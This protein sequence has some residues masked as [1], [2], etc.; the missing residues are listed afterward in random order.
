MGN[1][2]LVSWVTESPSNQAMSYGNIAMLCSGDA[3]EGLSNPQLITKSNYTALVPSTRHEYKALASYFKNFTGSPTN[4]TYLYWMGSSAAVSGTALGT[5]LIW[6]IKY[7]PYTS[8]DT[9]WVDPTG[10]SNWQAV[11]GFNITTC[12]SGYIAITGS[13]SQYN[14]YINF[15]GVYINDV[16]QGGPYFDSGGV[17]Y[18]GQIGRD[19]IDTSGGR[20]QIRATRSPF[21]VAAQN[22]IPEDIQ[23]LVAPYDVAASEPSGIMG[24]ASAV[25]DFRNLLAMCAGNRMQTVWALP[26]AASPGNSYADAGVDYENTRNYVGQDKNA[27]CIYVDVNT[28]TNGSG[29]DDPAAA[30]LGKICDRA[31]HKPL[32]LANINISLASV[33]DENEEASWSAGNIACI[34]RRSD[35]GFA[36]DQISYGFTFS[37]TS[38]S[39]RLN[40]VRCKYQVEYNVLADLWKLL[41]AGNLRISK[42]GLGGIIDAINATLNRLESEEIIDVG[43][44]HVEIPLINGTTAEWKSARLTRRVPAIIVRWSWNTSPEQLNITQF[45]EIL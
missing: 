30:Y 25:S 45:G 41:S 6:Y 17:S 37:G 9:V 13:H 33:A 36:T 20:L 10:G 29:L 1:H 23:F 42:S 7:P 5:D 35:L 38:P 3:P 32:T 24:D 28:G 31:P 2:I 12:P 40:N 11:S 21:G 15:S 16:D 4:N 18:S 8:V 43:N 39:N 19:I 22:I 14:G 27:S 34:F 44:R 26:K